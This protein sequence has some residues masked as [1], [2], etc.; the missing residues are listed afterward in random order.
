GAV[1][2][3]SR[4][5][6]N[7]SG[8]PWPQPALVLLSSAIISRAQK[9]ERRF[10]GYLFM[11]RLLIQVAV[12]L[13]DSQRWVSKRDA[14]HGAHKSPSEDAAKQGAAATSGNVQLDKGDVQLDVQLNISCQWLPAALSRRT[15]AAVGRA[16]HGSPRP[17]SAAASRSHPG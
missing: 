2:R 5:V 11:G 10:I 12:L 7:S 16:S 1:V 13:P 6:A 4:M 9:E 3:S 14:E 8:S 17:R 15:P